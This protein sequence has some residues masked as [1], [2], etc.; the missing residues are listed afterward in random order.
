MKGSSKVSL[1]LVL[2]CMAAFLVGC[3]RDPN[4]RKQKYFESGERYFE[5]GKYREAVIQYRNA[6]EVDGAFAAAHYKLAE[7]YLKLQDWQRAYQELTRTLELQP[8][9]YKA[10]LEAANLLI[11]AGQADQVKTA[12]DHV[13]VLMDKQPN[14]PDTH[15]AQASIL[16]K[17]KRFNEALAEMQK[18]VA[19]APSRGDAYY[20]LA[21]LQ[22]EMNQPELAEANFK[23]AIDLKA[24]GANPR[25]ALAAFY[26]SRRRFSEAEQQVQ[27]VMA[28]DPK[29]VDARSAM[30]KLYISEGK[31][32]EAESFLRQVKQDFPDNSVGYRMLGDFYFAIGDLDK[33]VA[34]Y[35][36][37]YRDH[38][39]D[40]VVQKNY[41]QLLILK[42][43]L[44][45]AD[46]LN[47]EILKEHAKD[48]DALTYHGEIQ[49]AQGKTS[50]AINTLQ[51]VVSIDP[52]MA[53]AHYQL[54]LA[55]N[56]TGDTDHAA[57]EWREALRTRPDMIEAHRMLAIYS[58]QKGDLRALEESA[59][60]MIGLQ[61][62]GPDG[63]AWRAA[64]LMGQKQFA[65]AEQDARKAI[66]VAP[67]APAG[68][69]QMGNMANLQQKFPQAESW[70]RQALS[71][72]K[73][74][75]EALRGL[76][77]TYLS[78]KQP[79]KALAAVNQQ[80]S[81]SPDNSS[82]YSLLGLVQTNK[83]DSI[84][85]IAAYKKALQL[86]K[87]NTDASLKLAGLQIQ[88]GALDDALATCND[89]IRNNPKEFGL[90]MVMGNVYEKKNDLNKAQSFYQKALDVKPDDPL[91]S[92]NVAYILLETN[93]NPDLAL[94]LAQTARR[95]K[96]EMS[97]IADTLGWAFYQKGIYGS[98]IS[99]FQEAIKLAAQ[100]KEPDNATYHYHLGLAYARSAQPSLAKQHLER[101]LKIDPHYSDADDVKKQLAQL[102][103]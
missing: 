82:F 72:D 27:L 92:N 84:S 74:S 31:G 95:G 97:N 15:V 25:L 53:V 26:Q 67:Q 11:A 51:S 13:D 101:V 50:E 87:K 69:V 39:K 46:K 81:Q 48:E 6:T 100:N 8:D 17:E 99:M 18:A 24:S 22:N 65:G 41:V 90:Y 14:D 29:D 79:D 1:F 98:A 45:E 91:A 3:S 28:A 5:K 83:H 75:F 40:L 64:A 77:V 58:L 54:G 32:A 12:Q 30:A 88:T 94:R 62:A 23:K 10:H 47:E 89:G 2:G 96:P 55:L 68:Y 38:A 37:L 63:Y 20:N 80:L 9:N 59:G 43:R 70:Y 36:S 61:P 71:L 60:K 33:A 16:E 76:V 34:E 56:Q 86:D 7:S 44:Q 42:N 21:L 4:V 66:E 78:Q 102:R 57:K 103:S 19:L 35:E 73:D 49:L 85:A 52:D 93:S